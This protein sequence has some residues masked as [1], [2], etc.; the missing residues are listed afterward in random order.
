MTWLVLVAYLLTGIVPGHGFVVCL[1]ADGTVAL[2]LASS[3]CAPCPGTETEASSAEPSDEELGRCP[4][5]DIPLP[6]GSEEIQAKPK[7]P[8]FPSLLTAVVPAPA[9]DVDA[10]SEAQ[11]FAFLH[12]SQP[13]PG[14]TLGLIRTVIL[15]V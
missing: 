1:E 4:C 12:R 5:I 10:G 3:R 2:E 13:R 9:L 14:P 11:A 7:L 6:S 8:D 15:R